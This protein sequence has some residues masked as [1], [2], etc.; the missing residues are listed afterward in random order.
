MKINECNTFVLKLKKHYITR[1]YGIGITCIF[2]AL[3]PCKII[4]IT[5]AQPPIKVFVLGTSWI[6]KIGSHAQK[7]PKT[8]STVV[9]AKRIQNTIQIFFVPPWLSCDI[10]ICKFK[11]VRA[12]LLG[13]KL[14]QIEEGKYEYPN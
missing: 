10:S 6:P 14:Y 13:Q 2:L 1:A 5:I 12:S 8:T 9:S 11:F 3:I 7:I 4:A